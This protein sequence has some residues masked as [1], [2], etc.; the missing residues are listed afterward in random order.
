M[1]QLDPAPHPLSSPA[2]PNL[3]LH[4]AAARRG[5]TEAALLAAECGE[6]AT[7]LVADAWP[8][9]FRRLP[10]LG[11][12][13]AQTRNRSAI[14][15]KI[16]GYTE[17]DVAAEHMTIHGGPIDLR[18]FP[19]QWAHGFA[20]DEGERPSL[21]FFDAHGD[22]VHA[23]YA[24]ERTRLDELRAL[25]DAFRAGDQRPSIELSPRPAKDPELADAEVDRAAFQA[26]W[27]ALK[28]T[29]D[30]ADLLRKYGV[31]RTQAMRLAPDGYARSVT[32]ASVDQ[33]LHASAACVLPIM[34][35]VGN[36]GCLQIHTGPI[37]KVL[38]MGPWINVVD[39]G[40]ILHLRRDRV[41]QAW[42]VRKP[43]VDGVVTSLELFDAEGD[44]IALLF[45]ER[46]PGRPELGAW[47]EL[48]AT[49]APAD[50]VSERT[51]RNGPV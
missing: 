20:V 9:L 2:H 30:F 18:V 12:L 36:P 41:A 34:I 19:S 28:D 33:V 37:G 21:H 22:P 32:R 23:I 29:H 31:S 14:H 10:R 6:T 4:D 42:I 8:E 24:R 25:V 16:G 13:L 1:S 7:R 26:D 17:P 3:R 15:E 11:E 40:F 46:K 47:R 43:T 50:N 35:F 5:V 45:G 49:L 38:D 27:R 39:P 51:L 48:L 44:T